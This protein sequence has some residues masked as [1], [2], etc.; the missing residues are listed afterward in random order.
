MKE[1]IYGRLYAEEILKTIYS[2][3]PTE[4]Q[5]KECDSGLG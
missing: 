1:L 5:R 3:P 4:F 2:L